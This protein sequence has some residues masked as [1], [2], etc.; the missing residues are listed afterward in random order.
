MHKRRGP[1]A[2]LARFPLFLPGLDVRG[3]AA[4]IELVNCSARGESQ[5]LDRGLVAFP[6]ASELN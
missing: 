1:R 2:K 5:G 4:V 6:W 3:R